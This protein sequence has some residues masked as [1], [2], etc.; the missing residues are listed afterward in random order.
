MD[1][2]EYLSS[3]SII[4]SDEKF[5]DNAEVSVSDQIQLISDAHKRLLDGK[6]AIIPRIQSVIGREFEGYKVDI[7]KN[8]NYINKII[9]NKS[10]NYIEDYLIDEGSRIIKKAQE[11]LSLLDLEIYFSII[12]RS[13]KR[14]EICLGRVD[15]SS[16]KRDKNEIIYIRSNKYIVYD[17]LESDCYNYIKKIKRRKKG[18]GIN[19]IIDEFVNKSALDQGSIKYLRILSIYP[20]E[21]M[22]ILNKCRNGRI[23]ITNEDVVSKFRNAKECD[24]IKLL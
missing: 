3:R 9:N 4:I 12:K 6:E 19:N 2:Y 5:K 8:K 10:T 22:K 21:S 17:L 16:L 11:T 24:G 18:Y 20:N 7:K 14:Y 1:I 13:M 23:D 15:E